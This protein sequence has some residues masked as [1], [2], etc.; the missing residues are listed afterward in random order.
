MKAISRRPIIIVCTAFISRALTSTH[1]PIS[2]C[3]I[4]SSKCNTLSALRCSPA[5]ITGIPYYGPSP[6][7]SPRFVHERP[8]A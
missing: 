1:G 6:S 5:S 2:T 7:V 3:T 4:L 8:R